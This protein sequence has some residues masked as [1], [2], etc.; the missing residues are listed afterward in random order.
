M[1]PFD[2]KKQLIL[3]RIASNSGNLFD[4][5]PK[6]TIDSL[7]LPLIESINAHPDMV[8]TSLCLG[9]VS[10][11]LEGIKQR[12]QIGAKGNEGKWIF[13]THEP[14]KLNNWYDSIDF[15]Y[16][17]RPNLKQNTRY[18]LYKFEP[19]ILHVRC[20]DLKT[21]SLLYS[22]VMGCGF[23]ESGIGSNNIVGIRILIKLDVPIA[24]LENDQIIAMVSRDYLE[25]ITELSHERFA[26]NFRKLGQL[27]DSI[28]KMGRVQEEVVE[29]KEER[30]ER[31]IREGMERRAGVKEDK[32]RKN[33]E[34]LMSLDIL[35]RLEFMEKQVPL[36]SEI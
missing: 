16:G 11:F 23:R 13:V 14:Q 35:E 1:L 5:S 3:R 10:V 33:F 22:N 4:A 34:K 36:S 20:R 2:Q 15:R 6:G 32:K 17:V 26:E 19:L 29:N 7:C 31:K 12:K 27:Q 18:I 28:A 9:R 21:A 24:Y 25:V 30:R 8:T